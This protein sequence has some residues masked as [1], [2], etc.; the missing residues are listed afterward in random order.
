MPNYHSTFFSL[1]LADGWSGDRDEEGLH[2]FQGPDRTGALQVSAYRGPKAV[3]DSALL[4]L[5][6]LD[7]EEQRHLGRV[8]CGDFSGYQ[9]VYAVE[10]TFWRKLW[11]SADAILLFISYNCT[12]SEMESEREVV[13]QII[14]SI[15]KS[16]VQPGASAKRGR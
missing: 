5:T 13:N 10:D 12:H 6:G 9:L 7:Q 16:T 8:T 2:T 4:E 1:T 3:T 14:A 11:V 15:R